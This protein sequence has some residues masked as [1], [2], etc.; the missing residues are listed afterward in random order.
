MTFI[1]VVSYPHKPEARFDIDHYVNVHMPHVSKIWGPVGLRSW[2]VTQ[3]IDPEYV[4]QAVVTWES[5]EAWKTA[6]QGPEAKGIF[7]DVPKFTN[8]DPLI[9]KGGVLSS[10]KA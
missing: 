8:L 3:P 4:I 2:A 5:M 10:W 9:V 1:V 7:D 6:S